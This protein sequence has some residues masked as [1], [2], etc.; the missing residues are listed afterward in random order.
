MT[1]LRQRRDVRQQ[2][3]FGGFTLWRRSGTPEPRR[4]VPRRHSRGWRRRRSVVHGPYPGST[5][6]SSSFHSSGR[7]RPTATAALARRSRRA[8]SLRSRARRRRTRLRFGALGVGTPTSWV[9]NLADIDDVPE[10]V[11]AHAGNR[12]QRQRR[13][14]ESSERALRDEGFDHAPQRP[15]LHLGAS[16]PTRRAVAAN[17]QAGTDSAHPRFRFG[18]SV[19]RCRSSTSSSRADAPSAAVSGRRCAAGACSNSSAARRRGASAAGR[20]GR[21]RC[22]DVRSAAAGGLRSPR[23]ERRSSTTTGPVPSSRRGRSAGAATL[24]SSQPSS[25]SRDAQARGRRDHL[26]SR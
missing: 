23:P 26:R 14:C 10:R 13:S 3:S 18:P 25:S 20:L 11:P 8:T 16:R 12:F 15:S 5:T 17:N 9:G 4:L 21:G 19:G 1:S 22:G 6:H 7:I 24:R 2:K